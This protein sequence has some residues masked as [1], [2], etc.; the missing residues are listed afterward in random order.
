MMDF[1][2]QNIYWFDSLKSC[3][4]NVITIK[5]LKAFASYSIFKIVFVLQ[6]LV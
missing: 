2:G 5:G 3:E 1:V 6:D 4:W